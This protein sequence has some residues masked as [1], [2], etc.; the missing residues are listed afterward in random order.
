[1]SYSQLIPFT[2][3][4]LLIFAVSIKCISNCVFHCNL[5]LLRNLA[6]CAVYLIWRSLLCLTALIAKKHRRRE[7]VN[8][9]YF[10]APAKKKLSVEIFRL[11]KIQPLARLQ[12]CKAV[13]PT[14]R[15]LSTS[16]Q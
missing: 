15:R 14:R 3:P 12:F 6:D 10:F 5:L 11:R 1:M 2:M 7:S 16:G 4:S 13:I 9:T 8:G